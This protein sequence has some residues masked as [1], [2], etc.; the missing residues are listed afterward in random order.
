LSNKQGHGSRRA[1]VRAGFGAALSLATGAP[2]LAR[3][4]G[5]EDKS[6]GYPGKP[7]RMV[8]PSAPG[9][10]P[11]VLA[12]LFAS[13]LS[14]NIGQPVVVEAIPGAS[15]LIGMER[16]LSAPADGYTIIYGF[17]QL[18]AMNPHQFTK[19]P[20]DVERDLAPV[21]LL[22]SMAYIW[23]AS[24]A[25]EANSIQDLVRLARKHPGKITFASPGLGSGSHLGGELMMQLAGIDMLH[26]PYKSTTGATTDL[27]AGTVQLKMDPYTTAVPLIRSGKVKA[28][29]VTAPARSPLLPDIPAVA[30]TLPG[31]DI[32]GWH[33]VWVASRTP[34]PIVHRLHDEFARIA[35][36]PEVKGQLRDMCIE[37]VGSSPRELQQA[38]R[39]E[40]RMWGE[41]LKARNIKLS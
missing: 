39:D 24:P 20:Y 36:S 13:K 1:F 41:L 30:E 33:A 11:D 2:L 6:A 23:I 17:N 26:V 7:I 14:Q 22:A 3:A 15:G 40:F 27:L 34:Q 35:H 32:P 16:A 31:Y 25:F 5:S 18:V 8:V 28:L 21:S 29:G 37:A 12:R 4:A 38:T 10:S 9:G 19:L